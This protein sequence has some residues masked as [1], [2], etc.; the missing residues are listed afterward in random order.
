MHPILHVAVRAARR[1]GKIIVRHGERLERVHVR[2]KG[3]NDFVS[4]V[5]RMAEDEIV[6][7][8]RRAYP[9][10]R[11]LAEERASDGE[12][13]NAGEKDDAEKNVREKTR[14]KSRTKSRTKNRRRKSPTTWNGS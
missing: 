12:I 6:E 1:A 7:A 14:T 2:E 4:E 3:R 8:V 10:H 11:I 9:R 5:D 13:E